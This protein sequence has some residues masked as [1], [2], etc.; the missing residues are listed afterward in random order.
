MFDSC[1]GNDDMPTILA[2]HSRVTREQFPPPIRHMTTVTFMRICVLGCGY[3]GAVLA[4]CLSDDGHRVVGVDISS[5][6]IAALNARRASFHE[7]GFDELLAKQLTRGLRFTTDFHVIADAELVFLAVGTPQADATGSADLSQLDAAVDQVMRHASH[8]HRTLVVGKSTVPVGT[9]AQI[10]ERLSAGLSGQIPGQPGS[11]SG[12]DLVCAWE[13]EFVREGHALADN[14]RPS[15]IVVGLPPNTDHAAYTLASLRACHQQAIAAGVPLITSDYAT[16][17]LV[18][19]ASNSFL[20]TKLSFINAMAE[21]CDATGADVDTLATA[22]AADPRIGEGYLSAGIGFGGGCLPKDV[23]AFTARSAELGV[24][25]ATGLLA[26]VSKIN[27]H[28]RSRAVQAILEL[29]PSDMS[30]AIL[31]ASFKPGSDDLRDSPALAI[32]DGLIAA[33]TQVR[34]TDPVAGP[35]LRSERPDLEVS[36]SA[37][38]AVTGADVVALL[39]PWPEYLTLEPDAL[40]ALVAHHAIFDGRNALNPSIWKQAGWR[41]RGLG[42]R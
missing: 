26:Q 28:T 1:E 29:G 14:R 18:K 22:M 19:V 5:Q 10:S 37:A 36:D 27:G 33:G 2:R 17:E 34:I 20:A 6:R 21:V 16:V 15:R 40:G 8:T 13:P 35:H 12:P 32:A 25:T 41:Y 38:E 31:G 24:G 11:T 30:V 39:T 9:A 3:L 42:R 4:A 23:R 7:P